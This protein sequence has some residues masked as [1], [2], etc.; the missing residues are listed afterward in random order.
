MATAV[1][2]PVLRYRAASAETT[3]FR[4]PGAM[5]K[6][7]PQIVGHIHHHPDNYTFYNRFCTILL[8]SYSHDLCL[9]CA[10]E[11]SILA[12]YRW[13]CMCNYLKWKIFHFFNK[14]DSEL[15]QKIFATCFLRKINISRH[16]W[17][18][19]W[20]AGPEISGKKEN[21]KIFCCDRAALIYPRPWTKQRAHVAASCSNVSCGLLPC[22]VLCTVLW[23]WWA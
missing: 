17:Q 2:Y 11:I 5:F 12:P 21:L 4:V 14:V 8:K 9:R 16:C 23:S 7:Q 22:D 6:I 1:L 20:F 10:T 19:L 15:V 3:I 13:H 18:L